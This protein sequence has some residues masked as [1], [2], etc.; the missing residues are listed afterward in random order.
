MCQFGSKTYYQR[1]NFGPKILVQIMCMGKK[2]TRILFST[3]KKKPFYGPSRFPFLDVV[4]GKLFGG[5][6]YYFPLLSLKV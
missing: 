1:K 4:M 6:C 2:E 5:E 3:K